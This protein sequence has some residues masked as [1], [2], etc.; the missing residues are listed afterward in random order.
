MKKLFV[1]LFIFSLAINV[2]GQQAKNVLDTSMRHASVSKRQIN[3]SEVPKAVLDAFNRK[4][5]D[6]QIKKVYTYVAYWESFYEYTNDEFQPSS[7]LTLDTNNILTYSHQYPAEVYSNPSNLTKADQEFSTPDYTPG[8]EYYELVYSKNNHNYKSV[9]AKDGT[10]M[11]TSRIIKDNE[12]PLKVA[13]AIR[14]G[15]YKTWDVVGEK[16]QIIKNDPDIVLYKIKVRKGEE[17]HVLHY[18]ENGI[19]YKNKKPEMQTAR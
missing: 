19:L 4:N 7:D 8:P 18:D 17:T 1:L 5:K 3:K 10:F 2:K 9:Y 15:P 13:N 6:T 14:T 12:L 16:E 11:H